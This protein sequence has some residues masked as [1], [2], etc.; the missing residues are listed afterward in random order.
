MAK[1]LKKLFIRVGNLSKFKTLYMGN[2]FL[3]T[4]LKNETGIIWRY[5]KEHRDEIIKLL[6]D[7]NINFV[8]E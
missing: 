7:R 8:I 5:E 2:D 6:K 4:V 3:Q 1:S